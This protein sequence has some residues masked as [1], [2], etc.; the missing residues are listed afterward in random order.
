MNKIRLLLLL[1]G[2]SL[3]SGSVCVYPAALRVAVTHSGTWCKI[4]D[5]YYSYAPVIPAGID[6]YVWLGSLDRWDKGYTR[7]SWDCSKMTAYMEWALENAGVE[8]KIQAGYGHAW[9]L[10]WR[11]DKEEWWA[12]ECVG[13]RWIHPWTGGN[14]YNPQHTYDD[15]HELRKACI[16]HVVYFAQEWCWWTSATQLQMGY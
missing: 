1:L 9:L 16:D 8:A 5:N 4:P 3:L 12:Y 2:L 13:L 7:N 6:P 11:T 15:M 14:Y 10:V